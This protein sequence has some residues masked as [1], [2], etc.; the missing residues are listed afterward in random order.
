MTRAR[1]LAPPGCVWVLAELYAPPDTN[2]RPYYRIQSHLGRFAERGE[3]LRRADRVSGGTTLH[4]ILINLGPAVTVEDE[5]GA[6][7]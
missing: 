1:D 6:K 3:A 5:A 2:E 7:P 4:A